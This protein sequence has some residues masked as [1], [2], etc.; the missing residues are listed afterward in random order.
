MKKLACSLILI[1]ILGA[2]AF[3]E[4][5]IQVS[6]MNAAKDYDFDAFSSLASQKEGINFAWTDKDGMGYLVYA[7]EASDLRVVDFLLDHG[8][9]VNMSFPWG[10]KRA[11]A[12]TVVQDVETADHLI[13]RGIRLN[14][15]PA[16]YASP[17]M[18]IAKYGDPALVKFLVE[19]G[20]DCETLD[21]LGMSPL[22]N[23]VDHGKLDNA[24]ILVERGTGKTFFAREKFTNYSPFSMLMR[25]DSPGDREL[26]RA[27]IGKTDAGDLNAAAIGEPTENGEAGDP[28]YPPLLYAARTKDFEALS[29]LVD[30]GVDLE[31]ADESGA[32]S[33][34]WAVYG[35]SLAAVKD[36]VEHSAKLETN[37]VIWIKK[38]EGTYYGGLLQIASE[39]RGDQMIDI[40]RYLVEGCGVD[41]DSGEYDVKTGGRNT[42]TPLF[43]ACL[44][45]NAQA[46]EYLLYRGADPDPVFQGTSLMDYLISGNCT[47]ENFP[48]L[49]AAYGAVPRADTKDMILWA[50]YKGFSHIVER[51]IEN[52]AEVDY[53]VESGLT[54]I[55]F[56]AMNG[57]AETIH[58]LL[59]HGAD[60]FHK[61]NVKDIRG[62]ESKMTAAEMTR[63]YI[64]ANKDNKDAVEMYTKVLDLLEP[65]R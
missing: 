10:S 1:L 14:E 63:H 61:G 44:S 27:I 51:L 22:Y 65:G 48:L 32:T 5:D 13:K 52:G 8:V 29:L 20:M 30:K 40:L 3:A 4:G 6:L 43:N 15:D 42:F 49:L 33:L 9:D 39:V 2:S 16:V 26:F 53:Q 24:R 45:G 47:D 19:S 55:F 64:E 21:D 41:V 62:V 23:A 58:V 25:G 57:H 36:L 12:L 59:A 60:P 7:V 35:G 46:A 38:D 11:S 54:A 17:L 18:M 28:A 31:A 34:M 50:S 56:A 37:G